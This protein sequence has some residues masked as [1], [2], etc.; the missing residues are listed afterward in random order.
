PAPPQECPRLRS[1]TPWFAPAADLAA[2]YA[3]QAPLGHTP[4]GE[5]IEAVLERLGQQPSENSRVMILTTDG[6]PDTCADGFVDNGQEP[7]LAAIRA[8]FSRGIRVYV[9]S[10][11]EEIQAGHLQDL[12]NAGIGKAL[13][14]P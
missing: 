9:V 14:D 10:V 4:T 12:A 1:P 3:S 2:L 5:A 7:A 6:E 11:G 13:D 8:A